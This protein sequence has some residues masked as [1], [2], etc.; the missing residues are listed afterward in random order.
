MAWHFTRLF[1]EPSANCTTSHSVSSFGAKKRRRYILPVLHARPLK[2]TLKCHKSAFL[3]LQSPAKKK[4]K[5]KK[6]GAACLFTTST[7]NILTPLVSGSAQRGIRAQSTSASSCKPQDGSEG[8]FEAFTCLNTC[9]SR[10]KWNAAAK[11]RVGAVRLKE[12]FLKRC[13]V[14]RGRIPLTGGLTPCMMQLMTY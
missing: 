13:V 5:T 2:L 6:N 1:W 14:D 9:R 4:T 11:F 3:L 12:M 8:V 7:I 10:K